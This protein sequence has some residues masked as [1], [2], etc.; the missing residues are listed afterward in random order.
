MSNQ[1]SA[2]MRVGIK[3]PVIS[4]RDTE[5]HGVIIEPIDGCQSECCTDDFLCSDYCGKTDSYHHYDVEVS[6]PKNPQPSISGGNYTLPV[7]SPTTL[8]GIKV[9]EELEISGDGTLHIGSEVKDHIDK[10]EETAEWAK[11]V[12][13]DNV[14]VIQLKVDKVPGKGLSTNDYTNAD[15]EKVQNAITEVKQ[16]GNVLP[17]VNGSVNIENQDI[18]LDETLTIS[19]MAADAKAT[20]DAIDLKQDLITDDMMLALSIKCRLVVPIAD[21]DDALFVDEEGFIYGL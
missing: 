18:E 8:G 15:K 13:E 1:Y 16:N 4:D 9:G 2:L 19:G 6:P 7:A 10:I 12:A 20:G 11:S 21:E 3:K 5:H 14:H 17:V